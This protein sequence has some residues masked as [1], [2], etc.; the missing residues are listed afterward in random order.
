M[1]CPDIP[2]SPCRVLFPGDAPL[3]GRSCSRDRGIEARYFVVDSSKLKPSHDL[4]RGVALPDGINSRLLLSRSAAD[5]RALINAQV[6][7]ARLDPEHVLDPTAFVITGPPLVAGD[8]RVVA[9]TH[10]SILIQSAAQRDRSSGTFQ[11]YVELLRARAGWFGLD[12][13][14]VRSHPAP[15]LVRMLPANV[16]GDIEVLRALNRLSDR[17][18]TKPRDILSQ[19]ET[20]AAHYRHAE[21]AQEV[22]AGYFQNVDRRPRAGKRRYERR[23]IRFF[24]R[25]GAGKRFLEELTCAHVVDDHDQAVLV[26]PHTKLLSPQGRIIL[27]QMLAAA[28]VGD[29]LAMDDIDERILSR[30]APAFPWLVAAPGS[31]RPWGELKEALRQALSL[32]RGFGGRDRFARMKTEDLEQGDMLFLAGLSAQSSFRVA[33]PQARHLAACL[34]SRDAAWFRSRMEQW[35]G[36]IRRGKPQEQG[37]TQGA[38]EQAQMLFGEQEQAVESDAVD[39][40]R[41]A[42]FE[43]GRDFELVFGTVDALEPIPPEVLHGQILRLGR[44][45]ARGRRAAVLHVRSLVPDDV[46]EKVQPVLA[47]LP[48]PWKNHI[49]EERSGG[50]RSSPRL[51]RRAILGVVLHLRA[52]GV[53][54]RRFRTWW[55]LYPPDWRAGRYNS[56]RHILRAWRSDLERWSELCRTLGIDPTG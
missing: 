36:P 48:Y 13:S 37:Q 20:M 31:L 46:W 33:S 55:D 22:F 12:E 21:A 2:G 47:R 27:G 35:G 10:R 45:G 42:P 43:F 9:G 25:G 52:A 4:T 19:A 44:G 51:D 29:A 16:G 14:A 11:R 5:H 38:V 24:L 49:G 8:Y 7:T 26:D 40:G 23:S 30:L 56:V 15:V 41:S 3:P 39:G 34:V 18:L 32:V 1:M 6:A 17:F 50:E 53:P 28:A 54:F